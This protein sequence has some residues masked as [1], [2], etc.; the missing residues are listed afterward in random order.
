V[1]TIVQLSDLHFGTILQPTIEPLVARV[2]ELKPDL[3]VISGD[4]TQRARRVQ[5]RDAV[6]FLG[7]LPG[8]QLVIPGNHDVPA[9]N[10]YRRL[11]QPLD[12]YKRFLGAELNPSFVDEEIAVLAVNTARAFVIK[13]GSISGAQRRMLE[14][15]LAALPREVVRIVVAHHPFDLPDG[16]SGVEIVKNAHAAMEIFARHRVDL[17]LGGHLH[18]AFIGHAGRYRIDGY[19]APINQAG[20]ATSTRAR[21]EPNSFSVIRVDSPKI[22]IDTWTWFAERQV[23]EVSASH[24]FSRVS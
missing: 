17:F 3:V 15:K 1:R 21:G 14:E 7:R 10:L 13:G 6:A 16:L 19:D 8:P 22:A 12:R 20:T 18:L 24:E 11:L 5:Y 4:L 2:A 9:Y 23:F